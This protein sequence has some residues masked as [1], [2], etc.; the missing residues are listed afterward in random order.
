M[1]IKPKPIIE[2]FNSYV[3]YVMAVFEILIEN[4]YL[5]VKNGIAEVINLEQDNI[6][7]IIKK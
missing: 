3:K 5:F 4:R 6:D 7:K 1:A 2:G